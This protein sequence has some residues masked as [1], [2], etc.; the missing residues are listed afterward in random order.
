MKMLLK[1]ENAV[2]CM[3]LTLLAA[4]LPCAAVAQKSH[5]VLNVTD[6]NSLTVVDG[7]PVDYRCVPDS[8][9]MIV[10]DTTE[11]LA[12]KITFQNNKEHLR[13]Q[14]LAEDRPLEGVPHVR[15]YSSSLR[16]VE[17]SGD[18]LTTVHTA[19]PVQ[20]FTAKQVSNGRLKVSKVKAEQVDVDTAAGKGFVEIIGEATTLKIRNVGNGDIDAD[21][22]IAVSA[23]CFVLGPG[24][25]DVN[26]SGNLRVTGAGAGTVTNHTDARKTVNRSIGIKIVTPAK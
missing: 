18:S 8:A 23:S 20:R 24:K 12:S 16:Y 3:L 9:G 26:V 6:F 22:L 25:V 17:N 5:Y 2:C 4:L 21:G 13:I 7:I 10:F 19:V 11:E 14:T 1:T 15:V